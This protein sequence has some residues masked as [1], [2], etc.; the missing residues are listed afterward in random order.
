MINYKPLKQN[1]YKRDTLTV[2]KELL[3]KI[4]VKFEKEKILTGIIVE[5]EA[6][7]GNN[8][9]ASH[10]YPGI[11]ERNRVMF[12]EGGKI[13]VYFVYGNHF[14]FNIVTE[15]KGFGSAVLIRAIEPVEGI[16]IMKKR[17]PKAKVIYELTNGPGKFCSAF[18]INR[19]YNGYDL[20]SG[21][22]ILTNGKT[23]AD[24]IISPRIGIEKGNNL[25][26][27]FFIRDNKFVS[28]HKNNKYTTLLRKGI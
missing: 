18:G 13:Y 27:R 23:D 3:G 2:A 25:L 1:F 17:R 21:S 22:I 12:E 16:D 11:T 4:I 26:Y 7:T 28:R 19:K 8:D 14:C 15:S 6:Y 20:T 5:T 9:P 24:I 10:S